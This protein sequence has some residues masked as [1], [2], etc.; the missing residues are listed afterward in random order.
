MSEIED[1]L[2]ECLEDNLEPYYKKGYLG[3]NICLKS[4]IRFRDKIELKNKEKTK[5][6]EVDCLHL[7]G[8]SK[9]GDNPSQN[10]DGSLIKG[11]AYLICNH[12]FHE[13]LCEKK[14]SSF[15]E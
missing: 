11:V 15:I 6:K 7:G 9:F 5:R 4:E 1:I 13:K 12:Q 10:Y 3:Y 2:K 14:N 8:F